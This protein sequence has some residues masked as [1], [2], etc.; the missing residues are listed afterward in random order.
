MALS[1]RNVMNDPEV[2]KSV[3]GMTPAD[4][5]KVEA[6]LAKLQSWRPPPTP[7][8]AGPPRRPTRARCF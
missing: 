2:A 3:Q 6:S 5:A 4:R 8:F 1:A 7:L